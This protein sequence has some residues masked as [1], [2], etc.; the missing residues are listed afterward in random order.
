MEAR[1]ASHGG[2]EGNGS[3]SQQRRTIE[4]KQLKQSYE[5]YGWKEDRNDRGEGE[6]TNHLLG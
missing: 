5:E 3:R 1:M 2:R 4:K 6:H